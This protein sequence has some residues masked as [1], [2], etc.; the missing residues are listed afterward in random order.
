M[1]VA[2]TLPE[3]CEGT[4]FKKQDEFLKEPNYKCFDQFVFFCDF[5]LVVSLD[6][7]YYRP[8]ELVEDKN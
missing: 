7:S 6:A 5:L 8:T 4:I 2:V 3:L 1:G